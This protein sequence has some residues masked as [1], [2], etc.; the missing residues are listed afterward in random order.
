MTVGALFADIFATSYNSIRA[1]QAENFETGFGAAI[2]TLGASVA[3]A[4]LIV[5]LSS[6]HALARGAERAIPAGAAMIGVAASLTTI[7]GA[8][9]PPSGAGVSVADRMFG[10]DPWYLD[11]T[12]TAF[13]ASFGL[14][15][16]LGFA[17]RS[18]WGLGLVTSSVALS[19][20]YMVASLGNEGIDQPGAKGFV[21]EWHPLFM[22][23]ISAQIVALVAA[24]VPH[25]AAS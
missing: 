1:S 14:A 16:L 21:E 3:S 4:L 8:A 20:W 24:W 17:R 22:V 6:R 5:G 23:G 9:L 12:R 2:F 10:L 25:L 19:G 15:G 7:V 18:S 11:I 13:V